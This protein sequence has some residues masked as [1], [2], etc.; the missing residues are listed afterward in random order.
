M[1]CSLCVKRKRQ[2]EY[3]LSDSSP[4]PTSAQT[5]SNSRRKTL[6][7]V[8]DNETIL[9]NAAIELPLVPPDRLSGALNYISAEANGS[10]HGLPVPHADDLAVTY[11]IQ[12]MYNSEQGF[13]E[14]SEYMY[15]KCKQLLAESFDNAHDSFLVACSVALLAQYCASHEENDRAF[16]YL[17]NVKSFLEVWKDR[18]SEQ[19]GYMF[20]GF[21]YF[22]VDIMLHEE[23]DMERVIK[24][25]LLHAQ[26][27][28]EFFQSAN[29]PWSSII[30]SA[31][32]GIT[33]H[34]LAEDICGEKSLLVLD[35]KESDRL[36]KTFSEVCDRLGLAGAD[37]KLIT[38]KKVFLTMLVYGLIL[39]RSFGVDDARARET[40][41]SIAMLTTTPGFFVCCPYIVGVIQKAT[42]AH[43]HFSRGST[44]I[45]EIQEISG[46]LREELLTLQAIRK[47]NKL[48]ERRTKV[49]IEE[50]I[51]ELQSIE[52][53][54][55]SIQLES[56][57]NNPI[58]PL[59][60]ISQPIQL[61]SE[62]NLTSMVSDDLFLSAFDVGEL[63]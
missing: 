20:L 19:P 10:T 43:I 62:S 63:L 8:Y 50:V 16:F 6:N 42:H 35:T 1:P 58:Q 41:D 59:Q 13:I 24:V 38:G 39:Q 9:V 61:E 17:H 57:M 28:S 21:L 14:T 15:E 22:A 37:R 25:M 32:Y 47:K 46:H 12:A 23:T 36:L 55:L 60:F 11:A 4:Y 18:R 56:F 2:C 40:A 52:S 31:E 27:L 7:F 29:D 49:L 5:K 54:V 44:D 53:K 26:W 48:L 33:S 45:N 3:E 34:E 30:A 51:E